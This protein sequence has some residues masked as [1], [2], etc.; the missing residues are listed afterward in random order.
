MGRRLQRAWPMNELSCLHPGKWVEMFWAFLTFIYLF[1]YLFKYF[2]VVPIISPFAPLHPACPP[3]IVNP[4]PT[5]HVRR[6]FIH[7]PWLIL[8]PST[9]LTFN[10]QNY[11][12]KWGIL[13]P[14]G[15]SAQGYIFH[16]AGKKTWEYKKAIRISLYKEKGESSMNFFIA[17]IVKVSCTRKQTGLVHT[18]LERGGCG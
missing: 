14:G 15:S 13:P 4:H 1:T 17:I 3:S 11:F 16:I 9:F 12:G 6:S 7:I 10:F 8:L 18:S 5:V 2:T